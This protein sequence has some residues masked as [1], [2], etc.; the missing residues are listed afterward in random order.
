[1]TAY[2][3]AGDIGIASYLGMAQAGSF[4]TEEN[5]R[6]PGVITTLRS[7]YF[8][9]SCEDCAH[10]SSVSKGAAASEFIRGPFV[11]ECMSRSPASAYAVMPTS[12]RCLASPR[13]RDHLIAWVSPARGMGSAG[14]IW[15]KLPASTLSNDSLYD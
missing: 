11:K 1:M 15:S 4:E 7:M 10:F 14:R 13:A 8:G 9:A 12:S 2:A 6:S 5:V 3:E